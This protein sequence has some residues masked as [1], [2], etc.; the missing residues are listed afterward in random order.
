[1]KIFSLTNFRNLTK[2]TNWCCA[3]FFAILLGFGFA[4]NQMIGVGRVGGPNPTN[5]LDAVAIKIDGVPITQIEYERAIAAQGQAIAP[6]LPT[7]NAQATAI[8]Q[9]VQATAIKELAKRRHVTVTSTDV[10]N[11]IDQMRIAAGQQKA[12]DS[13]WANYVEQNMGVSLAELRKQLAQSPNLLAQAL[14]NYY[15]RQQHI[16]ENDAKNLYT[17]VNLLT[18]FVPVGN[19]PLAPAKSGQKPLTDTQAQKLINMLLAKAKAGADKK[20]LA[21]SAPQARVMQTG[22]RPE[23]TQ[24]LGTPSPDSPFGI[25][26]YGSNFDAAVHNTSVN[27]FTP[28]VKTNGFLA[29]YIFAKVLA[30][31]TDLPKQFDARSLINS[32]QTQVAQ[33]QFVAELTPL[34]NNARIQ[35]VDPDKQPYVDAYLLQQMQQKQLMAQLG[36]PVSGPLPTKA[37]IDAL[38]QKELADF[39]ALL[40]HHPNDATAALMVAQ[41]IEQNKLYAKGVTPAQQQAYRQQLIQLYQTALTNYEDRDIRFKLADLYVEQ[42]D[43]ADAKKQYELIAKFLSQQPPYNS[44]TD[45]QYIGYYQRLANAFTALGLSDEARKMQQEIASIKQQL[46]KDQAKEAA[47]AKSQGPLQ[48]NVTLPPGTKTSVPLSS[49]PAASKP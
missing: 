32:L 48:R 30:R 26:G 37:Q 36:Q 24:T 2:N 34:L 33:K 42:K 6:G 31:K 14:L 41:D 44:A 10:D 4:W 18:V 47:A 12:S 38:Q 17:Q 11:A 25:L 27:G 40:K 29:G 35:V 45:Q 7:V 8:A 28:I 22:F 13:E 39:Q 1:M 19:S 21:Q 43:F 20:A 23:Y 5:S 15:K 3:L 16:T 46:A 49:K 9:L